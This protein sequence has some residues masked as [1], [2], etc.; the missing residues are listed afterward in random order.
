MADTL[1][2]TW[3]G[4][5]VKFLIRDIHLP[6]PAAVVQELVRSGASLRGMVVDVSDSG[7]AGGGFVVVQC[8]RLRQPCVLPVERVE[9]ID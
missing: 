4:H 2:E 8:G 3:K 9:R 7:T 6:E 5:R 1:H